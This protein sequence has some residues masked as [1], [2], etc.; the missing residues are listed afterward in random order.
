MTERNLTRVSG[1]V[2]L[3]QT[4]ESNNALGFEGMLR[5]AELFVVTDHFFRALFVNTASAELEQQVLYS[6][7][8]RLRK[9]RNVLGP[10]LEEYALL[11]WLLDESDPFKDVLATAKH[12][13]RISAAEFMDGITWHVRN[14]D[15]S[16]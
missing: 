14:A 12:D 7:G 6:L 11:L 9:L 5:N 13:E 2:D 1:D 15:D 10:R 3:R 4:I 16:K 8:D